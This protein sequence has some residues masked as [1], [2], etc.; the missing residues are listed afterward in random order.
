MV[1][2]LNVLTEEQKNNTVVYK[3]NIAVNPHFKRGYGYSFNLIASVKR[4]DLQRISLTARIFM[5]STPV[6]IQSL[7]ASL[8]SRKTVSVNFTL[9][10]LSFKRHLLIATF[11][12]FLWFNRLW[13]F[14]N[15]I[16]QS[17]CLS[18]NRIIGNC[19]Y[20]IGRDYELCGCSV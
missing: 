14:F 20:S 4:C 16:T 5:L 10:V 6:L 8:N 1:K 9:T 12:F 17:G 13:C 15:I 7:A 2:S 18:E 3:N 19:I 11:V